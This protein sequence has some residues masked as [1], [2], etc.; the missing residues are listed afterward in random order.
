M[1]T[2]AD[3]VK[4][5]SRIMARLVNDCIYDQYQFVP[6]VAEK[7]TAWSGPAYPVRTGGGRG[8]LLLNLPCS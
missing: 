8:T 2:V 5:I 7:A 1:F 4:L 6:V 3:R